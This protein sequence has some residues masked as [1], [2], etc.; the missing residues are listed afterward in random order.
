MTTSAAGV[1]LGAQR[2]QRVALD[3]EQL[4]MACSVSRYAPSP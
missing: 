3:A 1:V 2:R 4:L